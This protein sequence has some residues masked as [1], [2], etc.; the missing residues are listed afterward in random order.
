MLETLGAAAYSASSL[1][2]TNQLESA[3]SIPDL[4]LRV[5]VLVVSMQP[6][7]G[8]R[9]AIGNI[10]TN[11]EISRDKCDRNMSSWERRTPASHAAEWSCDRCAAPCMVLLRRAAICPCY[12]SISAAFSSLLHVHERIL[13]FWAF[14]AAAGDRALGANCHSGG[15][16]PT[17]VRQSGSSVHAVRESVHDTA[18]ARRW[19]A[20]HQARGTQDNHN[21]ATVAT[22]WSMHAAV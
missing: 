4:S 18:P 21:A 8:F 22:A 3:S 7:A 13:E 2:A 15:K 12:S 9:T 1:T 16:I 19:E 17:A 10:A 14:L 11:I 20:R 5:G 6:C